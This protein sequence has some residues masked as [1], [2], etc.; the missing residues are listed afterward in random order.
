ME[1]GPDPPQ[2]PVDT[3]TVNRFFIGVTSS[4]RHRE[5]RVGSTPPGM[6]PL[7]GDKGAV[8]PG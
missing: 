8:S 4:N 7:G 6:A 2:Q 1:C 5:R 3:R